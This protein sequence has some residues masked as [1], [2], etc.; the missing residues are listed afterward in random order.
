MG[1][2]ETYNLPNKD[3]HHSKTK[4]QVSHGHANE[5]AGLGK[6]D[7]GA[8][9]VHANRINYNG[10]AL[11]RES[12]HD[13]YAG[14]YNLPNKDTHHSKTKRQ[15]S[16]GHANEHA[17]LGKTDGGAGHVHANRINYNGDDLYAQTYNLPNKDTHH[18]KTKRQVSH[19]HANEHAGLGKTDGGAGHIHANRINYN[20][21]ALLRES[22]H[23][24]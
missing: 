3:T 5:H 19:G 22:D 18:S 13:L 24:L 16:H 23:D 9:H 8:G 2:A 7:G 6:T 12:D 21:D 20:G 4:R 15:V 11:L 17:G 10:D 1:P 14:T